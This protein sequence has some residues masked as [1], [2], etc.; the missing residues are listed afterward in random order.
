M[1]HQRIDTEIDRGSQIRGKR[2]EA[3]LVNEVS[4]TIA[5]GKIRKKNAIPASAPIVTRKL[6]R[7]RSTRRGLA[8]AHRPSGPAGKVEQIDDQQA[9]EEGEPEEERA[10]Q[11]AVPE[12]MA[13]RK[14]F[15]LAVGQNE[16]GVGQIFAPCDPAEGWRETCGSPAISPSASC[17]RHISSRAPWA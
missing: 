8:M 14:A 3:G 13:R 12:Q 9:H 7:S 10:A 17:R 5:V 2:S 11:Q 1:P 4:S 16:Q 15:L 6:T